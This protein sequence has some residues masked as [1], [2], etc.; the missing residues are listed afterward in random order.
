MDNEEI[1]KEFS[2]DQKP[3]ETFEYFEYDFNGNKVYYKDSR[4]EE[5]FYE[6]TYNEDNKIIKK[7][8]L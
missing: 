5:S 7:N 8:L 6:Y 4:R 1:Y 3:D 2:L